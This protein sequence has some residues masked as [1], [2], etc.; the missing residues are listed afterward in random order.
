MKPRLFKTRSAMLAF[1]LSRPASTYHVLVLHDQACSASRCVCAP[2][3][4]VSDLTVDAVLEGQRLETEWKR[5][6]AS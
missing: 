1:V 3:F 2:W 4:E 5:A 6:T